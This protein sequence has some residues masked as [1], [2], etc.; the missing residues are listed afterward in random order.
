MQAFTSVNAAAPKRMF[1]LENV[2][3]PEV[4]ARI[5]NVA[6]K[7]TAENRHKPTRLRIELNQFAFRLCAND[8]NLFAI[9]GR[10]KIVNP[11]GT[12]GE[13]HGCAE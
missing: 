13:L 2:S 8:E 5:V 7:N 11:E 4:V 10:K 6:C 3:D 1:G 9:L 12:G